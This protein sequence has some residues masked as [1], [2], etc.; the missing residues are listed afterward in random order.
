MHRQGLCGLT[1]EAITEPQQPHPANRHPIKDGVE[2]PLSLG[3]LRTVES[4]YYT[5]QTRA[6]AG[7]GKSWELS[8]WNAQD[9]GCGIKLPMPLANMPGNFTMGVFF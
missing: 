2:V 1:S 9:M 3:E 6:N 5:L 7:L 8:L 4:L